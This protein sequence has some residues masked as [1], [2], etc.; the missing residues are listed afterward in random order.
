MRISRP[1]AASQKEE[2]E[3]KRTITTIA[4][5]AMMIFGAATHAHAEVRG[6]SVQVPFGFVAGGRF[7]P[8]GEYRI[9]PYGN[10]SEVLIQN[11]HYEIAAFASGFPTDSAEN[12]NDK[13]IFDQVG[14]EYFLT[15]IVT[16][17]NAVSLTFPALHAEKKASKARETLPVFEGDVNP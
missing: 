9:T 6:I 11:L 7:L 8:K 15:Q 3:M 14:G 13:L 5:F 2:T 1:C 17:S 4:V 16:S 12:G 10:R